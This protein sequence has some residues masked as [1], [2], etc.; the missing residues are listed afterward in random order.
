MNIREFPNLC[1]QN[2]FLTIPYLTKEEIDFW[3]EYPTEL[4]FTHHFLIFFEADET[5]DKPSI[6]I[7][8][9]KS[10]RKVNNMDGDYVKEQ[11][12]K[13]NR[14]VFKKN[15]I[16]E[17]LITIP[18]N[19]PQDYWYVDVG[20]IPFFVKEN[21]YF[22]GYYEKECPISYYLEKNYLEQNDNCNQDTYISNTEY[23]NLFIKEK[24]IINRLILKNQYKN[25][26]LKLEDINNN[27]Y[28]HRIMLPILSNK[29]IELWNSNPFICKEKQFVVFFEIGNK[30]EIK[31]NN[32]LT[33]KTNIPNNITTEII[34]IFPPINSND[35]HKSESKKRWIFS[36][37]HIP[38][39]C[40]DIIG[41]D[42][43]EMNEYLA[44]DNAEL[45]SWIFEQHMYC[46]KNNVQPINIR[47]FINENTNGDFN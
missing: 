24:I 42:R 30:P 37:H 22:Y 32:I 35:K 14:L 15:T 3:N 5:A 12:Q 19:Y 39:F 40:Q 10:D 11:K 47:S 46:L 26:A 33:L 44:H 2:Y 36:A 45:Y 17:M 7:N 43:S 41:I 23:Y 31:I 38:F 29:D 8:R 9:L 21:Q 13:E 27:T 6:K 28:R 34:F 4:D 16:Y 18:I 25:L 1:G 20:H